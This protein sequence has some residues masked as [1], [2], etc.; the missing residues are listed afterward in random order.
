MKKKLE[1]TKLVYVDI[2]FRVMGIFHGNLMTEYATVDGTSDG[3]LSEETYNVFKK[4]INDKY[5]EDGYTNILIEPCSKDEFDTKE[6]SEDSP[7][8]YIK[9]YLKTQ[10]QNGLA[11]QYRLFA[12]ECDFHV[13]FGE[14]LWDMIAD[15]LTDFFIKNGMLDVK[16]TSLTQELFDRLSEDDEST[17]IHPFLPD[18]GEDE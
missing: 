9:I 16:T 2:Y 18:E 4:E 6:V 12:I 8:G 5:I 3:E 1:D 14:D 15:D 13:F 11:E 17:I 7:L 10:Y